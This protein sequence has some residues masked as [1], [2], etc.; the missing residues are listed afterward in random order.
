MR[1]N[2]YDKCVQI[3]DLGLGLEEA[4][5]GKAVLWVFDV[6]SEMSLHARY[7]YL[8]GYAFRN[9]DYQRDFGINSLV[10]GISGSLWG[11]I[12]D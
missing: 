7:H 9:T 10:D 1:L 2:R 8:L 12:D 5:V 4:R 11:N 3:F 6:C